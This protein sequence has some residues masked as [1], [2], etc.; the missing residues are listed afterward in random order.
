MSVFQI[1]KDPDA[2]LDYSIDWTAWLTGAEVIASSVWTV[3]PVESPNGILLHD[4]G[5][6]V[7]NKIATIWIGGGTLKVARRYSVANSIVT[8][9]TPPRSEQRIILI[10]MEIR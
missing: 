1:V 4:G 6:D 9:S 2:D 3:T 10:D 5:L 7:S 8:N